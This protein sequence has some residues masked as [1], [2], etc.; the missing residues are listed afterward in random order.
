MK[1][2]AGARSRARDSISLMYAQARA[3]VLARY[4]DEVA[5]EFCT[6]EQVDVQADLVVHR[7]V[8]KRL[9]HSFG[10]GLRHVRLLVDQLEDERERTL[11]G[12]ALV[13]G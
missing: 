7:G 12:A 4:H 11:V 2:D 13:H 5:L 10:L 9:M 6:T 1:G 8:L 3:E